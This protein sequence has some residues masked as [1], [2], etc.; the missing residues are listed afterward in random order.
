MVYS[1]K[2]NES[3][4]GQIVRI[5]DGAQAFVP[6]P[7]PR[8]LDLD[9]EL[10]FRLDVASRSVAE[11]SGI[12]RYLLNP[13]LLISPFLRREAVLSSRIEGTQASLT[14]LYTYEAGATGAR[15]D[16]REVVNYVTALE[17]GRQRLNDLPISTRLVYEV[18]ALLMQGV[19]GH[20]QRPG[21][22]RSIQVWIGAP[23]TPIHNARFIPP[24]ARYIPDLLADW[25]QFVNQDLMMPPLIRCAL[26]H[27]QFETIHPFRDGNGR[28]GRLL[29]SLF[30]TQTQ[31]LQVPLLYLSAYFERLRTEYYDALL[32]VSITGSWREWVLFFLR[33]VEEQA[34]DAIRR[35][36][37]LNQ[38]RERY[39]HV[40]QA[41]RASGN[42]L[43][44]VDELFVRPIISTGRAADALGVTDAGARL[45]LRRLIANGII[46]ERD[47]TYPHIFVAEEILAALQ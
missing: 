4:M 6:A 23:G 47:D 17:R 28:I 5:E 24:P 7:L 29:I 16:T 1:D 12:G 18:H 38:L 32:N 2:L 30:L 40:L 44:L 13:N 42:T 34:T 43:Q 33:G 14:D 3:P 15:A 21:E 9:E 10:V 25:E 20:D 35:T 36:T 41:A 11:L 37:E 22:P 26:M 27:Y 8:H 46:T 19:R 31:V 39:R 45:I